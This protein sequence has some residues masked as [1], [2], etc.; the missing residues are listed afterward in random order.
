MKRFFD[1]TIALLALVLLAPLFA[2]IGATLALKEG[3]PILYR[4][5]RVGKDGR[6]FSILKFRTMTQQSTL[7]GEITVHNDARVTSVGRLLRAFKLDELTQLLNVLRNEMS[8]VGPRP[9]SPHFV[10]LYTAEQRAV[11]TVRPGITGPSQIAFRHEERLL[12]GPDP[13]AYYR[14]V[15]MPAKLAI[16]LEYVRSQSLWLDFKILALTLVSLARPVSFPDSHC[17][18]QWPLIPGK[19]QIDRASE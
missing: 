5:L 15:I 10:A 3:F 16:D 6:A 11:L 8:L 12:T 17:Q 9:E 2:I 13:E 7:T 1:V 18:A 19:H 14:T 4:G